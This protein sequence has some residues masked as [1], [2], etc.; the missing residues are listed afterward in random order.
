MSTIGERIHTLT[1]ELGEGTRLVAVSKF[2]PI[3]KLR[4]AYDAGQRIFGENRVQELVAKEPEMPADVEWHLI[5]TLQ[6]NKVKYIVPF[7]HTIE[8]VDSAALLRE[9]ERQSVRRER[10][11]ERGPIRCLLQIHIS[12]EETKHGLEEGEL[13]ELLESDLLADCPHVE[14]TGLMAMASLT[15]D[16]AL[17]EEQ[18]ARMEELFHRIKAD[19]FADQESFCDLSIGMSQDYRIALRHGATLVRIGTAIFGPREY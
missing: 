18:F 6:R 7:V 19:Y 11:A 10:P 2:H 12:G 15:D 9:I 1:K 4:E 16:E 3:E 13:R 5:G 8:S 17:V 14:V